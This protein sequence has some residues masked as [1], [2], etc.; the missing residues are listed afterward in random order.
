MEEVIA[1]VTPQASPRPVVE[2]FNLNQDGANKLKKILTASASKHNAR[3]TLLKGLLDDIYSK[4]TSLTLVAPKSDALFQELKNGTNSL[5]L[6]SF[7]PAQLNEVLPVNQLRETFEKINTYK[8]QAIAESNKELIKILEGMEKTIFQN[9]PGALEA[10]LRATPEGLELL[11][12]LNKTFNNF[13]IEALHLYTRGQYYD[14]RVAQVLDSPYAHSTDE[15]IK[16]SAKSTTSETTQ[17]AKMQANAR[18]S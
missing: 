8:R 7:S 2:I 10:F 12:N 9:Y 13:A 17:L 18:P 6:S 14:S 1:R 16:D 15:L 5:G 11:D 4:M 3:A